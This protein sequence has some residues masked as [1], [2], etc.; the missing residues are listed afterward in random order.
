MQSTGSEKSTPEYDHQVVADI[1]KRGKK[2]TEVRRLNS[3]GDDGIE[4]ER[5][6]V[7]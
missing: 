5:R 4:L 6:G 7:K 3:Q 1:G 2:E